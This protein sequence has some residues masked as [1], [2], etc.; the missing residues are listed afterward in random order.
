MLIYDGDAHG[1]KA[2][3]DKV[4]KYARIL[5]AQNVHLGTQALSYV[6]LAECFYSGRG[7]SKDLTVAL[8]YA[9]KAAQQYI[10]A[11]HKNRDRFW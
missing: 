3:P 7:I 10:I 1:V 11:W 6:I 2:K 8:E 9:Q 5:E 4:L